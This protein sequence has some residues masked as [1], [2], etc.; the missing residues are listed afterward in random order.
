MTEVS[1]HF[2]TAVGVR[3]TKLRR[4]NRK[5]Q[6]EDNLHG[7]PNAAMFPGEGKSR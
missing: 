6:H 4:K 5:P 7:G 1:I 2:G 3:K